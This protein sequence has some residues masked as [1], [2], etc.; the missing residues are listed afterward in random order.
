M[1]NSDLK[2]IFPPVL[3][4]TVFNLYMGFSPLAD[5]YQVPSI[6][7][8]L[9]LM[10]LYSVIFISLIVVVARLWTRWFLVKSFGMD[11]WVIIP[12]EVFTKAVSGSPQSYIHTLKWSYGGKYIPAPVTFKLTPSSFFPYRIK[13]CSVAEWEY[14]KFSH[15]FY[16]DCE[17]FLGILSASTP[18]L[19]VLYNRCCTKYRLRR[20]RPTS[21]EQ[22]FS[23]V[24]PNPPNARL[25]DAKNHS[26]QQQAQNVPYDLELDSVLELTGQRVS[27]YVE[28]TGSEEQ[29]K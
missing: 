24:N 27:I 22:I 18:A 16:A 13:N 3:N 15:A 6:Q 20:G 5:T 17:V 23:F 28:P 1:A 9:L 25:G 29:T 19:S 12:A 8:A 4:E 26:I 11:D 10:F 21:Q 14:P 7:R 2:E